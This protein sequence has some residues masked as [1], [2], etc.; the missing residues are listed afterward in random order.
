MQ[1]GSVEYAA[2]AR[3]PSQPVRPAVCLFEPVDDNTSYTSAGLITSMTRLCQKR[4]VVQERQVSTASRNYNYNQA[5]FLDISFCAS[6]FI[7]SYLM[8]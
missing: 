8:T 3:R 6:R 5:H 4:Q 2:L 1:G 7:R